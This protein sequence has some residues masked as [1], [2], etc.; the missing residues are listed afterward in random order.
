MCTRIRLCAVPFQCVLHHLHSCRG[1][2]QRLTEEMRAL[3]ARR[4]TAVTDDRSTVIC[5]KHANEWILRPRALQCLI[6][7]QPIIKQPT[8][9]APL[10]LAALFGGLPGS[11]MHYRPCYCAEL[12]KRSNADRESDFAEPASMDVGMNQAVDTDKENQAPQDA[13]MQ[14]T[15]MIDVRDTSHKPTRTLTPNRRTW[16]TQSMR[17]C[18]FECSSYRRDEKRTHASTSS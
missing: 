7:K 5:Q 6:C 14:E 10:W 17:D 12:A 3:L 15:F 2:R 16:F 9:D 8:R 11:P 4:C 1:R 13:N 18:R